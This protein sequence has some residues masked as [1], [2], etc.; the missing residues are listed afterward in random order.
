MIPGHREN[1]SCLTCE[2]MRKIVNARFEDI[3]RLNFTADDHNRLQATIAVYEDV[4]RC[5]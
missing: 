5:N 3:V 1:C 4:R 2:R